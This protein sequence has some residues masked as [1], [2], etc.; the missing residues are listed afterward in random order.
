MK[1]AELLGMM[2]ERAVALG[3]PTAAMHIAETILAGLESKPTLR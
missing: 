1:N 3:R 2:R